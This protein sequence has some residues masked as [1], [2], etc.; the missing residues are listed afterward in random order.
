[1]SSPSTLFRWAQLVRLPNTFTIIADVTAAFLLV[2][3]G[4]QP[5]VRLVAVVLAG[6]LLYWAGMVLNDVFDIEKD[7]V[8]RPGRPLPAGHISLPAARRAGW[9]LLL[10]GVVLAAI[11]GYLPADGLAGSWRPAAVAIV[12]AIMIVA[13][14]GPFKGSPAAPLLMGLCRFLSFLLGASVVFS[15]P[16]TGLADFAPK[17][18][19]TFA[20]GMGVYIMGV[21]NMARHEADQQGRSPT[22]PIGLVV[23]MA[24]AVLLALAPSMAPAGVAWRVSPD[25]GFP[26]LVGLIA[27]AVF[28][29]GIRAILDPQPVNLQMLIRVA[30]LTV[31]PFSAAIALLAAGPV[32][33]IGIFALVVP[34]IVLSARF[35]VT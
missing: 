24:G 8:E 19:W 31:I 18:V 33:A 20:A 15:D 30:V 11:S 12:L 2:A 6:I 29:R 14:D 26:M 9:G 28:V 17:H 21:T 3:Q 7:R 22:L 27:V 5:V 10:G 4:G 13:Y 35:R 34:A 16:M 1:M 25:R 23:A 32:W